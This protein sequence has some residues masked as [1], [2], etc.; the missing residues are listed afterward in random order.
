MQSIE[1]NET[2]IY[3]DGVLCWSNNGINLNP[4]K[5]AGSLSMHGYW[6]INLRGKYYRRARVVWIMHNGEIPEGIEVDHKD[7]SGFN[8]TLSNLRL[9]D[10]SG[11]AHNRGVQSNNKLGIPGVSINAAGKYSAYIRIA[12]R[13]KNLGSFTTI[14]EASA[15]YQLA[16][17]PF[18]N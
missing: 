1:F 14:E 5:A 4:G 10:R 15:A 2:F 9:K 12:G 3:K 8:D 6:H 11:N 18:V 17:K 16:K 7:R 13:T